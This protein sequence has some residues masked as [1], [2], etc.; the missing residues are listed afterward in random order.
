MK[1]IG[2]APNS[3]FIIQDSHFSRIVAAFT[4]Y[5]DAKECVMSCYYPGGLDKF[6]NKPIELRG[7][8]GVVSFG[9]F[10]PYSPDCQIIEIRLRGENSWFAPEKALL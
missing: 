1:R 6:G 8:P 9:V 10:S 3:I 2:Q 5:D 7:S 4:D